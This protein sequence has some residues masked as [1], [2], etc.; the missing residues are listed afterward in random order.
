MK[1][2]LLVRVAGFFVFEEESGLT[3]GNGKDRW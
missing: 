1:C 2:L 3:G